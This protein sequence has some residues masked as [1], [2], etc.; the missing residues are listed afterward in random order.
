MKQG[1]KSG[2]ARG[3]GFL[4]AK[5][6]NSGG[7]SKEERRIS[8]QTSRKVWNTSR[9]Y[10]LFRKF[11]NDRSFRLPFALLGRIPFSAKNGNSGWNVK[12][13]DAFRMNEAYFG[14]SVDCTQSF[15]Y[16]K[17]RD[18]RGTSLP[19]VPLVLP[20]ID[21]STGDSWLNR[22]QSSRYWERWGSPNLTRGGTL[23]NFSFR[24][25]KYILASFENF[26]VTP[27]QR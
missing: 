11:R 22:G 7:M 21:L 16:L 3:L 9:G 13:N 26:I 12:R 23:Q 1:G 5:T 27:G 6:G 24:P 4:R 10:P 14:S 25:I 20:A 2:W 19:V 18:T 8:K 17:A 15:I